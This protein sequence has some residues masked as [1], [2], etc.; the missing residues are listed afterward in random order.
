M[1]HSE[2]DI[3]MLYWSFIHKI[4]DQAHNG[5]ILDKKYVSHASFIDMFDMYSCCSK[6]DLGT[7]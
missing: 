3:G 7:S 1:K 5:P 4:W 2:L 6:K